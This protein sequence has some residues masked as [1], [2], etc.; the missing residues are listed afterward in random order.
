MRLKILFLTLVSLFPVCA[1]A[2]IQITD[3]DLNNAYA[4]RTIT[5]KGNLCHDPSVIMDTIS[6]PKTNPRYYIYGSHLGHGYTYASSNYQS[7][8]TFASYE[9]E[10]SNVSKSLFANTSGARISYVN[11]YDTHA[12]KTVKNYKGE[13]VS[14]GNFNAHNWQCKTTKTDK[15]D[16]PTTIAGMQ[17]AA[18]AIYNKTMKKWCMYMSINSDNWCSVIVCLT[19]DKAEGPWVY[20][21]PVI[22]SGFAGKW[23]HVGFTKTDDWKQ[24]DLAIATGCTSLPSKYA[25]SDN[26]GDTWPNCIDP[27]V[28]YDDDDNLWMSYGSWSGGIFMIRLNK[29]NGLRDY[30]YKFP[31]TGSGSGATSDEYFGKKIAGGYYS[32][33]EASYI[34][35]IG[36]YYYLFMSYGGLDTK[37]GYQMRIFRSDKPDGPYK[38]PYGTSAIYISYRM[39]YGAKATDARGM[40]LFGG[41]KWEFMPYAEIAQGHNSAITD[42]L[43]RSFVVYHT[44]STVGHEGHEVRVHQLFLN[45]D[46]WIMAAPYEFSGETITNDAIASKASIP[47]SEIPGNYQFMR[48]EYNQDTENLAYETPVDIELTADGKITGGAAGTWTRTAGTDFISLTI[49]GVVYKGVLVRQT[50]DYTNISSLCI[51]ACSSSSGSLAIGQ[52]SFTY[53]QNIWCSKANYKAAIKY[54]LENVVVPFSNGGTVNATQ[55]LPV[56]GLLGAQVKWTSSDENVMTSSGIVKGSGKVVMTMSIEKD[57]YFYSKD[58]NLTVS[59]GGEEATTTYYP[60]SMKKNLTSPF[61][62]NFS[63]DNYI[64]KA[65]STMK[66]RFYNYTDKNANYDN[67]CLYGASATH[68]ATGYTE[69]FGVRCDNWDNTTVSNTG[70]TS[71]YNWDTFTSDMDGSIVDMNVEYSASGVFKMTSTITTKAQK[72]YNYSYTKTI[73]AKPSQITLFFVSE[74]SYI[75]GSSLE[76]ADGIVP[77]YIVRPVPA[78][79]VIYNLAGQRVDASYKGVVIKNGKKY[80][81]NPR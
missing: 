24:T 8:T 79:N 34:E 81:Q 75:D 10:T 31:N 3:A 2:Q 25:P 45:Q 54:T 66:F 16:V 51:S 77:Q 4:K 26:Y 21:G 37:G 12:V 49:S 65:G 57:G 7:W 74:K 40:L 6:Y 19:S 52:K 56:K 36:K 5:R 60:V 20:Q 62:D 55:A 44:R 70:C 29:E 15:G 53:Q 71:N 67:W 1:S 14:F 50:I 11:A 48:H 73:S 61:W 30:T 63:N 28:F 23:D 38:D 32:S 17:W 68:G 9:N 46:G 18:D 22:F 58:Y 47:D 13:E 42:H 64:L 43:G 41:Y 27:C 78:A 80:M 72:V 69:Y 76:V 33:G 35:K 59:K 39:N